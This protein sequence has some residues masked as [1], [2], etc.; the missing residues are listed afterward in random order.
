MMHGIL[1]AHMIIAQSYRVARST[2]FAV[3]EVLSATNPANPTIITVKLLLINIIIIE[4]ANLTEIFPHSDT[5]IRADMSHWLF[6]ITDSTYNLLNIVSIQ[7]MPIHWI[8]Q[9]ASGFIVAMATMINLIATRSSNQAPSPIMLTS[10]THLA[11]IKTFI[12]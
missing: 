11:K 10:I 8:A 7:F 4:L 1:Y 5:A 3:E 2:F 6:S 12:S 9:H